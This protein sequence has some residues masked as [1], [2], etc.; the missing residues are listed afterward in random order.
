MPGARRGRPP[1]AQNIM[2]KDL[3]AAPPMVPGVDPK[4]SPE[5]F[6]PLHFIARGPSVVARRRASKRLVSLMPMHRNEWSHVL[7]AAWS[8]VMSL[9]TSWSPAMRESFDEASFECCHVMSQ[10]HQER[11]PWEGRGTGMGMRH[12]DSHG[13]QKDWAWDVEDGAIALTRT[14]HTRC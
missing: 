12:V 1:K 14:T 13:R 3:V 4:V 7:H 5:S 9:D 8:C 6:S 10:L 2:G 11:G